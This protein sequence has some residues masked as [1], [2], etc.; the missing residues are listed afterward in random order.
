[1]LG[2]LWTFP[3]G[4]QEPAESIEA[5]CARAL[6]DSF[7]I[8]TLVAPPTHTLSH[9]YSHFKITLHA[10]VCQEARIG[11]DLTGRRL[12]WAAPDA[13]EGLAFDRA[14]RRLFEAIAT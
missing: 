9:A 8:R 3:G 1:M 12:R 4:R 7:S 14:S 11:D 5:A 10:C 2:G 13:A 6:A